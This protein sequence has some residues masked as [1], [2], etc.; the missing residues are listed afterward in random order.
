MQSLLILRNKQEVERV[1]IGENIRR[2]RD[3]KGLKQMYVAQKAGIEPSML[4]QIEKG[5]KN[6]SIRTGK[7][8]AD[9]LGC[10]LDELLE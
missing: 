10:T 6:P 5:V 7:A 9:I 3:Q 4:C 2:I 8:I 1:G